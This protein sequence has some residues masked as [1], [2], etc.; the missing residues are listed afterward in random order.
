MPAFT[1]GNAFFAV[2]FTSSLQPSAGQQICLSI[3]TWEIKGTCKL[4][5]MLYSS[6]FK[7]HSALKPLHKPM[8]Q[9]SKFSG[10]ELS[11]QCHVCVCVCVCVFARMCMCDVHACVSFT[12]IYP[13]WL[14]L[15][16]CTVLPGV[17]VG[18]IWWTL[19]HVNWPMGV[20]FML[21]HI[22]LYIEATT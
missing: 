7:Q 12:P 2:D 9:F 13:W 20:V 11:W 17:L 5:I 10:A 22:V 14:L 4:P 8:D 1:A 16:A 19:T 15:W 3:V 18:I 6:F 21:K